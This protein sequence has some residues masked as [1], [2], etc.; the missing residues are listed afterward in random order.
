MTKMKEAIKKAIEG[1]WKAK[2]F[3]CECYAHGGFW[4]CPSCAFF[5]PSFWQSLGKAMEWGYEA[6][7]V[8]EKGHPKEWVYR[9]HCSVCGSV[10]NDQE[11]GCPVGC[12]TDNAPVESWAYEWHR[13]IDHLIAGK[14]VDSFFNEL[15][16]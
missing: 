9:E 4:D 14:D 2:S 16:Q 12:V 11:E 6:V 10:I 13:F 15:I 8:D 3:G 1:G 5:D 7:M